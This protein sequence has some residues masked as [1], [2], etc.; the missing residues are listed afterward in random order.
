M[1]QPT[2]SRVFHSAPNEYFEVDF[3]LGRFCFRSH[4]YNC[5][6]HSLLIASDGHAPIA[7]CYMWNYRHLRIILHLQANAQRR[8][9][10]SSHSSDRRVTAGF[11]ITSYPFE[12][13]TCLRAI[14]EIWTKKIALLE[15][16]PSSLTQTRDHPAVELNGKTDLPHV[17]TPS[18][19]SV[20]T[21]T[22]SSIQL[23]NSNQASRTSL[24]H[25]Q[26]QALAVALLHLTTKVSEL[27]PSLSH[28][29]RFS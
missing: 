15:V 12:H 5:K 2:M 25:S 3:F 29:L 4:T 7:R 1:W 22:S 28:K 23:L 13:T 20:F 10:Y 24:A 11:Q 21:Q 17:S 14:A 26:I 9:E 19:I 27:T 16:P 6:A 8:H 18:R